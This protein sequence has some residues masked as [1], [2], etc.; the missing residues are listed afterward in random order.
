MHQ[1]SKLKISRKILQLLVT[2]CITRSLF[3]NEWQVEGAQECLEECQGH[4]G[5]QV[6][7]S[8][9]IF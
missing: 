2:Y 4:T 5:C 8:K 7:K 6:G 3:L 9:L 1:V